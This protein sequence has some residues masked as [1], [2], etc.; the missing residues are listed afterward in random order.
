MH[1][2][3][4]IKYHKQNT[5]NQKGKSD[6][7][8][9]CYDENVELWFNQLYEIVKEYSPV[10]YVSAINVYELNHRIVKIEYDYYS[11][12]TERKELGN[13]IINLTKDR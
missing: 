8:P 7:E 12:L 11:K 5:L 4:S 13:A 3:N 6:I 1:L 2:L 10:Y 9:I